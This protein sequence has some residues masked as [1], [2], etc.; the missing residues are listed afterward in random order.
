MNC[1]PIKVT[2]VNTGGGIHFIANGTCEGYIINPTKLNLSPSQSVYHLGHWNVTGPFHR[3][4]SI[5]RVQENVYRP[6]ELIP[7]T[8]HF[9]MGYKPRDL[10]W[11]ALRH[12][13]INVSLYQFI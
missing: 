5:L 8:V 3:D 2:A 4:Y 11:W 12:D 13:S 1:S 10:L 7:I 9:K 6:G